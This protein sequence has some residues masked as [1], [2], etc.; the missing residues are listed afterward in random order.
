LE[1][2]E[3]RD[4]VFP[5]IFA[6]AES[7]DSLIYWAQ[8]NRIH[9]SEDGSSE[10][11]YTELEPIPSRPPLSTLRLLSS[12]EPLSD[13]FQRPYALC[14]TPSVLTE[15]GGIEYAPDLDLPHIIA[16]E[17]RRSARIHFSRERSQSIVDAKK[18]DALSRQGALRCEACDFDFVV[19]YGAMGEGFCEVHHVVPLSEADGEIQTS[20]DDLAIVC[21][22]CHRM[23]HRN[24]PFL[25]VAALRA[26]IA[27]T[28]QDGAGQ[29]ATA[30]KSQSEGKEKPKPESEGRSQ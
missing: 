21:A 6:S 10:I 7:T 14:Y 18:R 5:I 15:S 23:I 4:E 8:V 26:E 17:G 24:V 3:S 25:T 13:N 30:P 2:A 19:F 11:H 9:V 28:E 27:R 20:L 29:P 1:R 22:N 16:S 12:G